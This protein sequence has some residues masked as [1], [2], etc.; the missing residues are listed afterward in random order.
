MK[1]MYAQDSS[2]QHCN[3]KIFEI[4]QWL[5]IGDQCSKLWYMQKM[6]YNETFKKNER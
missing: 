5:L 1:R 4:T 6:K 2:L 3:S